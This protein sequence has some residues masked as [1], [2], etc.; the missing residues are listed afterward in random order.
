MKQNLVVGVGEMEEQNLVVG[1]KVREEQ[2]MLVGSVKERSKT[3][4]GQ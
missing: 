1:F 4:W 3:W 2:N